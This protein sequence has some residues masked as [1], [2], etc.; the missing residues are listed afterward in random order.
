[1]NVKSMSESSLTESSVKEKNEKKT[2]PVNEVQHYYNRDAWFV[3]TNAAK[4]KIESRIKQLE[5]ISTE[6]LT[7]SDIAHEEK[8][9][10]KYLCEVLRKAGCTVHHHYIHPTAFK[11][12]YQSATLTDNTSAPTVGLICEYDAV[13][14]FG[15]SS[16][17]NLLTEATIATIIGIREAMKS[18]TRLIGRLIVFGTPASEESGGKIRMM[19]EGAFDK[20]D[21]IV[22]INPSNHNCLLPKFYCSQKCFPSFFCIFSRINEFNIP[23][24]SS[25]GVLIQSKA[26]GFPAGCR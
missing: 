18:D 12:V 20:V 7:N 17:N 5:K 4:S 25:V 9:A 8:E 1:M 24:P 19:K 23:F 10:H 6:I 26:C 22:A 21:V 16:G 2:A 13:K 15:H 3:T 11:A 14:D